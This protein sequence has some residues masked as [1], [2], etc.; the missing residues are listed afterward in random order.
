MVLP[1][2]SSAAAL[3]SFPLFLNWTQKV[4]VI[5]TQLPHS[6]TFLE[7]NYDADISEQQIYPKLTGKEFARS[8]KTKR[9][10]AAGTALLWKDWRDCICIT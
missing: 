4:K 7:R 1:H 9:R 10:A 2:T 6:N 3:G 8:T 5:L